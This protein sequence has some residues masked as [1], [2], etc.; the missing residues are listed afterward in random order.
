MGW[1]VRGAG[2]DLGWQRRVQRV[3]RPGLA[4]TH[5][6]GTAGGVSLV[7]PCPEISR[8]KA[9]V[10]K[11]LCHDELLEYSEMGHRGQTRKPKMD[12]YMLFKGVSPMT[13]SVQAQHWNLAPCPRFPKQ[14]S[15]ES[16][17]HGAHARLARRESCFPPPQ[18]STLDHPG[19]RST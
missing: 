17:S 10:R 15:L 6:Q 14:S 5:T 2:V 12:I 9:L 3:P 8:Y 13:G 11:L 1:H 7:I 19:H 18:I 4:P 16:A